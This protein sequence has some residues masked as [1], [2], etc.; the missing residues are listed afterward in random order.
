MCIEIQLRLENRPVNHLATQLHNSSSNTHSLACSRWCDSY[1]VMC[2]PKIKSGRRMT[3]TAVRKPTLC[4]QDAQYDTREHAQCSPTEEEWRGVGEGGRKG[5]G[6]REGGGGD[7]RGGGDG[8][9]GGGDGGGGDGGGGG[10][11]R[12]RHWRGRRRGRQWRAAVGDARPA[13]MRAVAI[14]SQSDTL[15][16]NQAAHLS[17]RT[18]MLSHAKAQ[19]GVKTNDSASTPSLTIEHM[20]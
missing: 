11:G 18:C 16:G 14:I 6:G 13:K 8:D 7:G 12:G 3:H 4:T 20:V 19:N 15:I 5:G 1:K 10:G 17:R 2:D 9:G